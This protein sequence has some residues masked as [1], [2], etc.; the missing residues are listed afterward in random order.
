MKLFKA[1]LIALTLFIFLRP[2]SAAVDYGKPNILIIL[3]DDQ[4]MESIVGRDASGQWFMPFLASKRQFARKF[5]QFYYSQSLCCPSRASLLTG[6]Y[7]HNHGIIDNTGPDGGYGGYMT[8][9][10]DVKSWP[11]FI[12]GNTA[13]SYFTALI[14]KSF[15]HYGL[16][17][18]L[19]KVPRG[20]HFWDSIIG[21][22]TPNM[23][24]WRSVKNGTLTAHV[25]ATDACY[26]TNVL[27]AEAIDIFDQ[28]FTAYKRPFAMLLAPFSPHLPAMPA[29]KYET[30]YLNE[31]F[32]PAAKPSFNEADVSDKPAYIQEIPPFTPDQISTMTVNWRKSIAS[33]RSVDDLFRNVWNKLAANHQLANTY[34]F[35]LSDNGYSWGE[36]RIQNKVVPYRQSI[37]S[38]MM[39]WGPG[40]VAGSDSHIVTTADIFPT[41][42]EI[43]GKPIPSFV[44]GRSL[45]PLLKGQSPNPWRKALLVSGL[46]PDDDEGGSIDLGGSE[47]LALATRTWSFIDYDGELE[48]YDLTTDPHE[49]NSIAGSLDPAFVAA[50]QARMDAIYACAGAACAA[51]ENLPLPVR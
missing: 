5:D 1:V 3:T 11:F 45:L 50:V 39:V 44:D 51:A 46:P 6:M 31:P 13:P 38:V 41:I 4:T 21:G 32:Q 49:L 19:P 16:D 29:K 14:G 35:F 12:R 7:P 47:Y 23:F 25:C 9:G 8:K 22:F 24:N 30:A 2:A 17:T 36:H 48:F 33:A 34:I 20:W 27:A 37:S 15:N 43:A 18:A 26:Q 40:V 28:Q 10:L 42:M